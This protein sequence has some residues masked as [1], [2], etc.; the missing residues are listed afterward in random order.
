MF[1]YHCSDCGK[2]LILDGTATPDQKR[3]NCTPAKTMVGRAHSI[4]V[5]PLS[6][7]M[8]ELLSV[9][10]AE[11]KRAELCSEWGIANKS[12]KSHGSN[13]SSNQTLKNLIHNIL[14]VVT[15]EDQLDRIH[16]LVA[17]RY[18]YDIYTQSMIG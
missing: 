13:F 9:K 2:T 14:E 17:R 8:T 11:K 12:H 7:E 6:R 5:P 1:R 16:G 4:P 10:D 15:G 18:R 3:C